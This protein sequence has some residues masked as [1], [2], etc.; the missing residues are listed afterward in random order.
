M[1][2]NLIQGPNGKWV[3]DAQGN[4]FLAGR[5]CVDGW[6]DPAWLQ[7]PNQ[8]SDAVPANSLLTFGNT[9]RFRNSSSVTQ[10]ITSNVGFPYCAINTLD[11]TTYGVRTIT[12]A[13]TTILTGNYTRTANGNVLVIASWSGVGTSTSCVVGVPGARLMAGASQIAIYPSNVS[14]GSA[15]RSFGGMISGVY[16]ASG[17]INYV[18]Q[19]SAPS[20]AGT[21]VVGNASMA[22]IEID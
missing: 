18:L 15:G 5:L 21:W 10:T 14:S 1:S 7:I 22:I 3:I 12:T 20:A 13:N 16:N 9:L 8:G 6:V 11:A 19:M 4:C 2:D 17:V